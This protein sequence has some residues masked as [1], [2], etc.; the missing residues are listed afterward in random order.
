MG[1]PA[2]GLVCLH[3]IGWFQKLQARLHSCTAC[4]VRNVYLDVRNVFID[5]IYFCSFQPYDP[6]NPGGASLVMFSSCTSFM[7][8]R[9][10]PLP[11]C[12]ARKRATPLLRVPRRTGDPAGAA[13]HVWVQRV[14]ASYS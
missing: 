7:T 5:G 6:C 3:E 8:L 2:P 9:A 14:M 4:I 10:G 13:W 11:A 12:Q 1:L